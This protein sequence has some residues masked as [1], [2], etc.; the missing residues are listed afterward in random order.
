[1][2]TRRMKEVSKVYADNVPVWAAV[3]VVLVI[4]ATAIIAWAGVRS[5]ARSLFSASKAARVSSLFAAVM[6]AWL[7]AAFLIALVPR[8]EIADAA[9]GAVIVL[10]WT[11]ALTAVGHGCGFVPTSYP[12]TSEGIPPPLLLVLQSHS[13]A[14]AV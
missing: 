8:P 11:L 4:V 2:K 13:L 5:A 3:V 9:T 1:M 7:A 14:G 12:A 6:A 10:G